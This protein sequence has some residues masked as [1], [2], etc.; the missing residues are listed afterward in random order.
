MISKAILAP[1]VVLAAWTMVMWLWMYVTRLPAMSKVE[2]L[3]AG[4]MT[5]G[6]GTDLDA[7]L[8]PKTQWIAHN[9]NHLHENP[10]IFYATAITL[11]IVGAGDGINASLAWIYVG[12][13]IAHSLVQAL[14]NRVLARFALFAASGV[15]LIMLVAHA[16]MIV[17][18]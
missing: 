16:V 15:V 13:R 3:D 8:P 1:V 4:K 5:G 2:G 17:L 10:T 11:S 9:Y 18:S 6:K 14:W 7:V 12:L